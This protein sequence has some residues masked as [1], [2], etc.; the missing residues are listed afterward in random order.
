MQPV[1]VPESVR[2]QQN[3]ECV[4]RREV[5]GARRERESREK[6]R[7]SKRET[8]TRESERERDREKERVSEREREKER[9]RERSAVLMRQLHF[10]KS[11]GEFSGN[12]SIW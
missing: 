6:N 8:E 7:D 3:R 10:I 11:Q 9:E 2:R 1:Y 12:E 5:E 4:A